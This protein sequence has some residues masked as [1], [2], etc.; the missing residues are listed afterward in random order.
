MAL[1]TLFSAT[2]IGA[3]RFANLQNFVLINAGT[4]FPYERLA[5]FDAVVYS[6]IRNKDEWNTDHLV[7]RCRDQGIAT[8]SFPWL[9]WNGYFPDVMKV[10][11]HPPH[12]WGYRRLADFAAE[13]WSAERLLAEA[14]SLEAFNPLPYA[15]WSFSA[16]R[17]HEAD[18]DIAIS[19]FIEA[20]FR[21]QR[22]FW[23]PDH[24][25]LPL[26]RFVMTAI[27]DRLG[28]ALKPSATFNEPHRD[29]LPILPGVAAA[30]GLT[31]PGGDYRLEAWRRGIELDEFI[32]LNQELFAPVPAK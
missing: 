25:T 26:Y 13:G 2:A 27:A 19:G 14:R 17:E 32:A 12:I 6:P 20:S 30:L 1:D 9:Q 18:T 5:Q 15:D 4:P 7:Q 16:L 29:S 8:I 11:G 31:F 24:P 3:H 23:T 21:A 10:E 22:L 28:L